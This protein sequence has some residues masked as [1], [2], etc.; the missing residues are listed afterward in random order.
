MTVADTTSVFAGASLTTS[1]SSALDLSWPSGEQSVIVYGITS[2]RAHGGDLHLSEEELEHEFGLFADETF[3][4]ACQTS[5][6]AS[7]TWPDY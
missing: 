1:K 6:V 7:E 2:A 3:E 5:T 4:W